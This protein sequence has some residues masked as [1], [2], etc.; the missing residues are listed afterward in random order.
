MRLFAH[1][2]QSQ[3]MVVTL[4][5]F[6]SDKRGTYAR[7]CDFIGVDVIDPSG[8]FGFKVRCWASAASLTLPAGLTPPL[9]LNL[10][11]VFSTRVKKL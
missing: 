10:T 7:I 11:L 5:Q 4:E 2:D 1:F 8:K 9:S 3:G 6:I